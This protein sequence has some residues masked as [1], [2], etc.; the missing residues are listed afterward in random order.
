MGGAQRC[1]VE[2][3]EGFAA[4][5]WDVRAA[6][7]EG[8]ALTRA[9]APFCTE[10]RA[11]PCGP[12]ASGEKSGGDVL[13]FAWQLPR[14]VARI[15]SMARDC[16]VV[17]AN[18]PR[19][20]P[21][22]A[23]GRAGRPLIHHVHWMVPQRKAAA[24]ARAAMR[25][26]GAW[27]IVASHAAARW[28][29]GAVEPSRITTVYNGVAGFGAAPRAREEVRSIA[30]LGRLSP[31]KGPLEFVRAAKLVSQRIGGLRFTV[32][33]GMVFSKDARDGQNY[34]EML[35]SE[36][37]GAPVDFL[38][39]TED[40]GGFLSRTD[41]LV[42][43]SDASDHAPRVILEAFAAGVPVL[44]TAVGA[45]P[46]LI[47]H[48]VTGLLVKERTPEA[49]ARAMVYAA[50]QPDLLNT[51]AARAFERWRER[52]TLRRFQSEVCDA[53]EAVSRFHHQRT[54]LASAGANAAA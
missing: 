31:E 38:G 15:A 45:I 26:S 28:L 5:G 50:S 4:R 32:C 10:I 29:E 14:Q 48:G 37:A 22:A 44:A 12:F 24:L 39:W 36:A 17:Y 46:E 11:L 27:A 34:V 54:P 42:V 41:L 20:L 13:R 18:G 53:V 6:V 40:I 7:P 19:V 43:P 49:L 33:G 8:G 47:E 51:L 30:M 25:K 9:L 35:R 16:D 21:A 3:V 23:L 52:Y 2:A 1:L